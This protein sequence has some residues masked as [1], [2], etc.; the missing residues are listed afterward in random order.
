MCSTQYKSSFQISH[1]IVSKRICPMHSLTSEDQVFRWIRSFLKYSV[2]FRAFLPEGELRYISVNRGRGE[3]AASNLT[4]LEGFMRLEKFD[5]RDVSSGPGMVAQLSA[6]VLL[7]MA[8]GCRRVILGACDGAGKTL[9]LRGGR[10]W[11]LPPKR[12][13]RDV[14]PE[15]YW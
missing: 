9:Y 14:L 12:K 10:F 13:Y 8:K 11:N 3:P 1:Q 6:A 4:C 7:M 2:S 5:S 15:A